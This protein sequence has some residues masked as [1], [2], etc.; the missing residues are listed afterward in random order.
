MGETISCSSE[1][2]GRDSS[3]TASSR[4]VTALKAAVSDEVVSSSS[5]SNSTTSSRTNSEQHLVC[6]SL[7]PDSEC[8]PRYK[9]MQHQQQHWQR[10]RHHEYPTP[11]PS[12]A[13]SALTH[14]WPTRWPY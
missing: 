6:F 5:S 4:M 3:I 2:S 12:Q 9:A 10:H 13:A 8:R 1:A 11:P 14:G 7:S